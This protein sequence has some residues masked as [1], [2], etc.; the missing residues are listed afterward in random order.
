MAALSTSTETDLGPP[1]HEV[2]SHVL[3]H[4]R[5]DDDIT[6]AHTTTL[7]CGCRLSRLAHDI[8][9]RAPFVCLHILCIDISPFA[10]PSSIPPPRRPCLTPW[11]VASSA[12]R[13]IVR[14]PIANPRAPPRPLTS[15]R[16]CL[17]KAHEEGILLRQPP[18]QSQCLGHQL[19]QG[20]RAKPAP[21]RPRSV[22]MLMTIIL[23]QPR[24]PLGQLGC[25]RRWCLCCHS[26]ERAREAPRPDPT[27]SRSHGRRP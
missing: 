2:P 9:L 7:P 3:T 16:T 11:L 13:S 18:H 26:S 24:V 4:S 27:V 5:Y 14:R 19:G 20:A 21:T 1:R 12:R 23:G 8:S 6:H 25:I 10:F 15:R 17:W 22:S